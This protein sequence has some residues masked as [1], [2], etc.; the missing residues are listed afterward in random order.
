MINNNWCT[1]VGIISLYCS[2]HLE[3][4]MIGC[5]ASHLPRSFSSVVITAVYI[6]PHTDNN[7]ALDELFGVIDR[8]ETSN[9]FSLPTRHMLTVGH[10][11]SPSPYYAQG[12]P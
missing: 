1:D 7:T 11:P 9:T 5:R 4:L 6:T 2:P 8:T 12:T 10:G 3:H